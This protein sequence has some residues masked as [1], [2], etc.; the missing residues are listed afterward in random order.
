MLSKNGLTRKYEYSQCPFSLKI[1]TIH[2]NL[3][4]NLKSHAIT[5]IKGRIDK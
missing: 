5:K 3:S 4:Q 1:I 2:P